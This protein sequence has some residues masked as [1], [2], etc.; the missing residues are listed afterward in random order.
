[1]DVI[2]FRPKLFIE[3]SGKIGQI[4]GLR[5]PPPKLVPSPL[6]NPESASEF[7]LCRISVKCLKID[8]LV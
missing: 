4:I 7:T 5:P 3:F 2:P 1:M 8:N 6:G